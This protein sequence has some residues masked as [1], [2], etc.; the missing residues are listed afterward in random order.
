MIQKLYHIIDRHQDQIAQESIALII[1]K[2]YLTKK[3]QALFCENITLEDSPTPL[4]SI[5][6]I[7]PTDMISYL[8]KL[9]DLDIPIYGAESS[10]LH[11]DHV[12]TI[13]KIFRSNS[14]NDNSILFQNEETAQSNRNQ[15]FLEY[16]NK[17]SEMKGYSSVALITGEDHQIEIERLS[18]NLNLE[19]HLHKCQVSEKLYGNI[20][21][22]KLLL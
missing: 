7:I 18:S 8:Q 15:Y 14:R 1:K 12:D 21:L 5:L 3:I 17:I 22:K 13:R 2:L 20:N 9:E 4:T 6:E 11:K 19:Y 10:K 16:I